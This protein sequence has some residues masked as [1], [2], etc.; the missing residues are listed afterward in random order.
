MRIRWHAEYSGRT[1]RDAELIPI[2]NLLPHKQANTAAWAAGELCDDTA[3]KK[4]KFA[5]TPN[6]RT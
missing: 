1:L 6:E 4:C 2:W 5:L 3:T